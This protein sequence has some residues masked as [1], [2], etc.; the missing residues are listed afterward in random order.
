MGMLDGEG[1]AK[2][3]G[4]DAKQLRHLIRKHKLV[5]NHEHGKQYRLDSA[6][7]ARIEAHSEVR[8]LIARSR[9]G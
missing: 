4:V 2:K 8:A 5:P 3:L 6:D 7:Q 1:L 9:H